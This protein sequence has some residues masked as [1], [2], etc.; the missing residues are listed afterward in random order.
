MSGWEGAGR[1]DKLSAEKTEPCWQ[2]GTGEQAVLASGAP[3]ASCSPLLLLNPQHSR[4]GAAQLCTHSA[5]SSAA[6]G[7][8]SLCCSTSAQLKSNGGKEAFC[9]VYAALCRMLV[10]KELSLRWVPFPQLPRLKHIFLS[11]Y[12][13]NPSD[14]QSSDFSLSSIFFGMTASRT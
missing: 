2:K 3:G 14:T 1:R 9:V 5:V 10:I 11:L 7:E 4:S 12:K 8:M 6:L 13:Q